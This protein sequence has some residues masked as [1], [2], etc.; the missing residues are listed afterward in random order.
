MTYIFVYS[1]YPSHKTEEVV[2]VYL[3]MLKKFPV[4]ESL[5]EEII[6]SAVKTGC[7]GIKTLGVNKVMEGKL[8]DALTRARTQMAMFLSIEGF[9]YSIEVWA[10]VEEGLAVIGKSLP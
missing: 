8:E 4:D 1:W 7:E 2:K 6:P 10:T 5:V 3:E 9:E